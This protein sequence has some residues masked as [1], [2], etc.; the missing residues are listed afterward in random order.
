MEIKK[1]EGTTV[2]GPGVSISLDG[3]ELASAV[4]L[5]LYSQGVMVR[6]PRTISYDGELL[7]NKLHVYVDPSGF[8]IHE[9]VKLDGG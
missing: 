4:D 3:D 8:V 9:G 2:Y 6:G 7:K 5:Y 1:G